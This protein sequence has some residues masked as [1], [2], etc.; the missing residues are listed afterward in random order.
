MTLVGVSKMM[1]TLKLDA[2]CFFVFSFGGLLLV[3]I[4]GSVTT[5]VLFC[6]IGMGVETYGVAETEVCGVLS[7]FFFVVR[8][9]NVN[10][11]H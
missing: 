10:K 8:G 9:V 5:G 2:S 4:D 3:F 11:A 1:V 6:A 7:F